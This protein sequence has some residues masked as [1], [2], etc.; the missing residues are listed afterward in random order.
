[1]MLLF[2][3]AMLD[4][5]A[6]AGKDA[7]VKYCAECHSVEQAVS[8]RQGRQEWAAT[9]EKMAGMGAKVPDDS[10]DAI[11]GYLAKHFG[12]DAPIQIKVNKA[13]AVDLESLL[14]LKRSEAAAVIQ[15]RGEHGDFKSLDDLRKVPGVDFK[16]I[17]AKK[18]LIVF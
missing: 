16:K 10:Y 14:L 2:L 1:M 4:I 11:L 3:M 8:L 6:G 7:T 17:E 18:D 15:Y 9:M 13:S 5:P 12:E